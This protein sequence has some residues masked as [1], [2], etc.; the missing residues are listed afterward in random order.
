MVF[1][2]KSQ[3]F[4]KSHETFDSR[5]F[6]LKFSKSVGWYGF[7]YGFL[8]VFNVFHQCFVYSYC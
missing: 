7:Y 4:G 2:L 6:F 1:F 3:K 8:V 5:I